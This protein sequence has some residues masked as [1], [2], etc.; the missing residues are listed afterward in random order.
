M[1]S[2]QADVV[3]VGSGLAALMAAKTLSVDKHVII[4]T[5]SDWTDSNSYLA[6]GGIAATN[7]RDDDP[8]THLVDAL[9]AG[10][11]HNHT[12]R[13]KELVSKS[14]S[15]I[16]TLIDEGMPFDKGEDGMPDLAR[17]GGHRRDRVLHAGGDATGSV[18]SH[19]M[20]EALDNRVDIHEH[21]M[22]MDLVVSHE[23]CEGLWALDSLGDPVLYTAGSVIIASG[24]AGHVYAPTSNAA[25]V[26]GD[27]LAMAVR[28]GALLADMEFIQFHP[29]LLTTS[30]GTFGLV[31]EAVRGEGAFIVNEH[32]DRLM[33]GIHPLED[34]APRDIVSKTLYE[35]LMKGKAERL[36]L[37]IQPIPHFDTRFPTISLLCEK[38][39]I[40]INSGLLPI[41]PG[42]HFTM[43]GIL[44]NEWG[45][46]SIANLFA[47]GEAACTGVHG[48]NRIASHS[49][50]EALLFGGKCAEAILRSNQRAE[51]APFAIE[52]ITADVVL[53]NK[54]E[55][56][57]LMYRYV[58]IIRD[59]NGLHQA[60]KELDTY[61][62]EV[63]SQPNLN[64]TKDQMEQL[65]MLTVSKLIATSALLRTESRGGHFRTDYPVPLNDWRQK[66]I[67]R[68]GWT[69]EYAYVEKA[70]A[71]IF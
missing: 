50:L 71:S 70:T 24:G 56:Q 19:H 44:T 47:C 25:S 2:F 64:L 42:A 9:A 29:T 62:W 18:L 32:G 10:H 43:G 13:T 33:N 5:K 63:L 67:V 1:K 35:A 61:P 36:Y 37:N 30:E 45:Q 66:Q 27:G 11:H 59:V 34:L 26:T 51:K 65:N 23:G 39:G 38:A 54:I 31:S 52:R 40:D 41:S 53:P 16:Q 3:I 20:K 12:E 57:K 28:A 15:I 14:Q 22:V 69:V 8:F 55:I 48:A 49:L 21:T 58:G 4:I 46:T 6:Q 17:E 7:H 60:V 68:G